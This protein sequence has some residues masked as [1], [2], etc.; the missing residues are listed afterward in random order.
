MW[1]KRLIFRSTIVKLS[2][3]LMVLVVSSCEKVIQ[4]NLDE[5][6]NLV[7][8]EGIITE[9]RV[10]QV[11][12]LSRSVSI[13]ESSLFPAVQGAVVKVSDDFGNTFTL[14]ES[15]TQPGTY[16]STFRA[17]AERIYVL[18]VVADG[19]TYT[20]QS[21]MPNPVVM[22]SLSVREFSFGGDLSK[23]VQAHYKDPIFDA[24]NYRFVL[25]V[26]GKQAS[27]IYADNDRFTNGNFVKNLLFHD[28]DTDGNLKSGD[29]ATVLMQCIDSAVFTYWYTLAQQSMNG[30]GGGTAPG[31][32]PSNISNGALGY[33]SAQTQS[34]LSVTIE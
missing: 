12:K 22:D 15:Q 10:P 4:V 23:Q 27:S 16:T 30:P 32:P 14:I 3:L 26:H 17:R 33:F 28:D 2:I 13:T 19:Q 18:N 5:A 1:K 24:N 7:V 9:G 29:T 34:S 6:S 11:V 20:A 21:K 8:I 31:N 25:F